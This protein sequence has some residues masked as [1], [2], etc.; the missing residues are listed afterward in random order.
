VISSLEPAADARRLL[1]PVAGTAAL[2]VAKTHKLHDRFASFR[3]ERS[4]RL[5][6]KDAGDVLR[7][8]QAEPP[9]Q[10]GA[11][12]RALADDAAAGESVREG[13]ERLRELFGRRRSPGVDLAVQA[14]RAALPEESVRALATA[15]TA[16][17]LDSY[18]AA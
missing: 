15:Y 17:L 8:M 4:D 11:R 1:V 9:D 10:V 2:L 6:P 13:V 14:L 18:A 12:L 16:A 3:P 7:L 5:K